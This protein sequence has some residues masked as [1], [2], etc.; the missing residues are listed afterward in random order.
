MIV[1]YVCPRCLEDVSFDLWKQDTDNI[2]CSNCK[3]WLELDYVGDL[4]NTTYFL[5]EKG[6]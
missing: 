4:P 3:T 5:V 6:D 2:Q 1:E